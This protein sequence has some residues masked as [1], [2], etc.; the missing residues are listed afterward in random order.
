MKLT[1]KAL[2]YSIGVQCVQCACSAKRLALHLAEF[3]LSIVGQSLESLA[4]TKFCKELG[5]DDRNN[6]WTAR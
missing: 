6:K 4:L 1:A 3:F 5:N 2:A